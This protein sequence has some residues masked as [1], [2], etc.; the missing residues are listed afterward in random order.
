MSEVNKSSR[1][2]FLQTTAASAVVAP[3]LIPASALGTEGKPGANERIRVGLIGC[4]GMGRSNLKNCAKHP[5]VEVTGACD[6]WKSRRDEVVAQYPGAKPYHDYREMLQQDNI[7]AVIIATPPHWHCLQAIDA[8]K[9]GKDIYL[10]KP[11][12]RHLAESLAVKNAVEKHKVVC[13]VGTQ[14]HASEN[15]RRVVEIIRSGN[16]GKISVVRS[17]FIMN[18]GVEG[19]GNMPDCKP[20]PGLDWEMWQGPAPARAFNPHIVKNAYDHGSFMTY[21]GGWT[22]GMAPHIIDLP[23]WALGLGFPVKTHCSGGRFTI[24]DAGDAPDMQE[25]LWQFEGGLTLA[26]SMSIVNS[27]GFDFGRGTRK[28]RLGIYFQGVRGTLFSD[29]AKHEIVAEGDW[30]D[31]AKTPEKS[32]PASPGH[33]REWLDCI[34]S[35]Q[36][37][38]CNPAYHCKLD[39]AIELANLSMQLGRSIHFDPKTEQIIGDA[40][41]TKMAIPQ[42]RAPWKFP[43]EYLKG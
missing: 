37:P 40:A 31:D 2:Q 20:H 29:Y 4:G 43:V 12:T 7:D 9:A 15:Y 25:T 22:P 27:F 30:M 33:E 23:F 35:R 36:Q 42:Y 5:D 41:A 17:F 32:I 8:C 24:Q 34:K 38:S 39:V 26:W 11:M 13:Q 19:I 6:V 14:I 21:S 16:L 28:R 3:Y 1:R 10:Q 18:Q